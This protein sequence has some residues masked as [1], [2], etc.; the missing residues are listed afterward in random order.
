MS[1]PRWCR[2]V[3]PVCAVA[4]GGCV[5]SWTGA[6]AGVTPSVLPAPQVKVGK[7]EMDLCPVPAVAQALADQGVTLEA[8]SPG[9]VVDVDGRRCV[10]LPMTRGE[11]ALDLSK[12]TVP[13]DG[14]LT[15]RKAGGG[16]VSFTDMAFDFG[17]H[18]AEGTAA[19]EGAR[20]RRGRQQP[21]VDLFAF[22]FEMA[23]TRVDVTKG[24]GHGAAAL[25]LGTGG[26]DALKNALGTSPLPAQ[27]TVFDAT[28]SGSVAEAAQAL[29]RALL[30]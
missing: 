24:T 6:A 10:Q 30:P 20:A 22:A 9:R 1:L 8:R 5:L 21:S 29:S 17:S 7:A 3:V 26:Y 11:F 12:G 18:K 14:G 15:F 27:G 13:A 25:S 28:A 2:L 4:A 16:A 19:A 23:K